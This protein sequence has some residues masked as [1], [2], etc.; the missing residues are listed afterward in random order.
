M[1][2]IKKVDVDKVSG[3]LKLP[4]DPF[5]LP[6]PNPRPGPLPWPTPEEPLS[7]PTVD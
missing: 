6:G 2:E 7:Q 3:G 4:G 5:P 1:Q